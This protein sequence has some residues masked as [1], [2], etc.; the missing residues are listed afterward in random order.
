MSHVSLTNE[1]CLVWM[2]QVSSSE[3]ETGLHS[4]SSTCYWLSAV[5]YSPATDSVQCCL[6]SM[7]HV[8]YEWVVSHKSEAWQSAS[9]VVSHKVWMKRHH[10]VGGMTI[11]H[12]GMT[13]G[14]SCYEW[15]MSHTHV[16]QVGGMTIGVSRYH[17]QVRLVRHHSFIPYETPLIHTFWD[18]T[19]S[20]WQ[21]AFLSRYRLSL[22]SMYLSLSSIHPS[23]F[24]TKTKLCCFTKPIVGSFIRLSYLTIPYLYDDAKHLYTIHL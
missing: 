14:V 22:S 9:R 20:A 3:R 10:S 7:R 13:I 23:S 8:W 1:S 5:L 19:H 11:C 21:K 15:V 2:S 17:A 16:S 6:V 18:T 12:G 24:T 4:V